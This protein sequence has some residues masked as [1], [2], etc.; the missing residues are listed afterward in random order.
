MP[1]YNIVETTFSYNLDFDPAANDSI[2]ELKDQLYSEGQKHDTDVHTYEEKDVPNFVKNN[3]C[4]L[5]YEEYQRIKN[6]FSN[7]CGYFCW[8]FLFIL[9]YS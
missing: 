5:N 4:S 1:Y 3:K 8:S 9:G 2:R 7:S 6:K